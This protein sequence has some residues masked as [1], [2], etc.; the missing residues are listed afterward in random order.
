M[1]VCVCACVCVCVCVCVRVRGLCACVRVVACVCQVSL[2]R[3]SA[4]ALDHAQLVHSQWHH[5]ARLR[6]GVFVK[7]VATDDNIADL[8]SRLVPC[9]A[10]FPCRVRGFVCVQEFGVLKEKGA[11]KVPPELSVEYSGNAWKILQHR[12]SLS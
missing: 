10:V 8:P 1:R 6:A 4:R 7:R 2:R 12:W 3:G 5:I 11:V 9:C